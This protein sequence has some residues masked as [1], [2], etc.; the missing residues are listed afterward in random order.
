MVGLPR[1][2]QKELIFHLDLAQDLLV[3]LKVILKRARDLRTQS[4]LVQVKYVHLVYVHVRS[5][6][7]AR[8]K[9]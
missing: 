5:A 6:Y 1:F 2:Q 4:S 3:K 7:S 9:T 8:Q